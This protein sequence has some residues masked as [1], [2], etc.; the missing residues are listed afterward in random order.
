MKNLSIVK[1]GRKEYYY[2]RKSKQLI[3]IKN[4]KDYCIVASKGLLEKVIIFR[5]PSLTV[6]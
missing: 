6:Y 3:N 1:I 4:P 5:F 2:N